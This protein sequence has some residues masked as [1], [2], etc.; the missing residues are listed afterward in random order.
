MTGA[1]QD[2]PKI[3]LKIQAY[4]ANRSLQKCLEI[5]VRPSEHI[6]KKSRLEKK[7]LKIDA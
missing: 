2:P 3:S 5:Q 4:N 6:L 1:L 7:S